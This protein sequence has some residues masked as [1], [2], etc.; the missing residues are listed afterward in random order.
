MQLVRPARCESEQNLVASRKSSSLLVFRSLRSISA[1]EELLAWYDPD[2]SAELGLVHNVQSLKGTNGYSCTVCS[3]NFRFPNPLRVHLRFACRQ[4]TIDKTIPTGAASGASIVSS[5]FQSSSVNKKPF[6]IA[7]ESAVLSSSS[8]SSS[9]SSSSSKKVTK[10]SSHRNHER[11]SAFHTYIRKNRDMRDDMEVDMRLSEKREPHSTKAKVAT[12]PTKSSPVSFSVERMLSTS[13]DSS[14][15]KERVSPSSIPIT[16]IN[17]WQPHI[18]LIPTSVGRPLQK[19]SLDPFP[20]TSL[21]YPSVYPYVRYYGLFPGTS[22]VNGTT[23]QHTDPFLSLKSSPSTLLKF[24]VGGLPSV[25][26][27]SVPREQSKLW[28]LSR[29]H[30]LHPGPSAYGTVPNDQERFSYSQSY[31]GKSKRGH[32]CIYCG[33]LYSR[34]YGLKI[35]L[36]T[37]TGYK[38]LKC[39]VCLRPFG[40]PSNLNKHIRLHAEGDTPYRCEHCGKVLVRRRDLE[41]HI[42]SRHPTETITKKKDDSKDKT[43]SKYDVTNCDEHHSSGGLSSTAT[44]ING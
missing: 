20:L 4:I 8:P 35:H 19:P 10:S 5:F 42:R 16:S 14:S 44:A 38:P 11:V 31:G 3:A 6:L 2:V 18:P 1:G 17:S 23:T 39:K 22:V 12:Q 25:A 24:P 21:C 37:H 40:D 33:K 9:T 41:R 32:L 27:T 28:E 13:R 43:E 15:Q 29:S 34:K 36:R 30:V 26:A 7:H